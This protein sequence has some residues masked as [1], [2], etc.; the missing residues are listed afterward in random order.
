MAEIAIRPGE[1]GQT[2]PA[3]MRWGGRALTGLV[4][5]FL[6]MD[7]SMKLAD[8]IWVRQAA[9]G[10]GWPISLDRPL[11]LIELVGLVLLLIPRTAALGAIYLTGLLGGAV[12]A[13]LRQGDPL[14]THVLFGVYVGVMMWG[15]QWLR[16]DRVRALIPFR[17]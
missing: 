6:A 12:A 8:A 13:H 10:I 15:G 7:A 4:A 2:R 9:T 11:G 5:L 17:R 3:A 1:G 14:F 16:D